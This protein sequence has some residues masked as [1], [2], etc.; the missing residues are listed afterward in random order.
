MLRRETG[1]GSKTMLKIVGLLLVLS[2]SCTDAQRV[3]P[4]R[5]KCVLVDEDEPVLGDVGGP[6]YLSELKQRRIQSTVRSG[7]TGGEIQINRVPD[8]SQ[9]IPRKVNTA[10]I[11]SPLP[12]AT[13]QAPPPPPPTQKLKQVMLN[14]GQRPTQV[15]FSVPIGLPSIQVTKPPGRELQLSPE[16]CHMIN[17]YATLYGVTD[18][19]SWVH[20]NCGFAKMYLPNSSCEEIDI[21]VASCYKI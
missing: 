11:R 5:Y 4:K 7:E 10:P 16:H 14:R 1:F 15:G 17:H 6:S 9:P 20:K 13:T 21:L 3:K 2:V 8:Y 19:T 12:L 18:V